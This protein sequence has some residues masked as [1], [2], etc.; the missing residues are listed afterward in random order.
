MTEETSRPSVELRT[1]HSPGTYGFVYLTHVDA[2]AKAALTG[3]PINMRSMDATYIEL[4]VVQ[5]IHS[6]ISEVVPPLTTLQEERLVDEIEKILQPLTDVQ[7]ES[8]LRAVD[9]IIPP[10]TPQ[11][12]VQI[13]NGNEEVTPP[14]TLEQAQQLLVRSAKIVTV[15]VK[16]ERDLLC[17]TARVQPELSADQK[18]QVMTAVMN[19]FPAPEKVERMIRVSLLMRI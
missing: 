2:K 5:I 10:L 7:Q 17:A 18:H 8:L 9:E 15:S 14:I 4:D 6:A 12:Q 19:Y 16:Q 3:Q 11:Q 13:L 1:P